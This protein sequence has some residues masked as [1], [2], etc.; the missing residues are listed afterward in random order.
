MKKGRFGFFAAVLMILFIVPAPLWAAPSLTSLEINETIVPGEEPTY[1]SVTG[2]YSDGSSR[3][4][5]D[6]TWSVSNRDIATITSG[7]RLTFTGKGGS[8]TVRAHKSGL[9]AVQTVIVTPW[10]EEIEIETALVVS[11]NPYRLMLLGKLSDGGERY[12][13]AADGVIWSTSNPFVAWVNTQ[14]IVTFTGE[15]GYV[16][17][18]AVLGNR[19]D[20]VSARVEDDDD[21]S[22]AYIKGIRITND[23]AYSAEPV[24]LVLAALMSDD[25]EEELDNG[26]ADW[27]SSNPEVVTVNTEGVLYFTGKAG[28]STIK[29]IYGGYSTEKVVTVGR[30]IVNIAIN[31]SLNYTNIWDGKTIQLSAT[32]KYNDDSEHVQSAGLTWSCDNK[33]VAAIS[34]DGRIAFTGTPGEV[35]VTV[36]GQTAANPAPVQDAITT[37]VPEI[38]K[39]LPQK[40]LI[41]DNPLTQ[42]GSM[43][44]KAS[45]LYSDGTLR[46]VTAAAVWKSLTPD[47]ASVFNGAMYASP[48]PGAIKISASWQGLT[49]TIVAYNHGSAGKPER[50]YQLRIKQHQVTYSPRAQQLQALAQMGDGT[51]KDVTSL[52]SWQSTQPG[53]ARIKNGVLTWTGRM[54]K[55]LIS[56]QGYGF[57]DELQLEALPAELAPRVERLVLEGALDKG[58]VQLKAMA[59]YN[60]GRTQDVT[61]LAVWNTSNRQ[62]AQVTQEGLVMFPAG[63]KPVEITAS[64]GGQEA[65]LSR[66][67]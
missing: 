10:P 56:I 49:D 62:R 36:S 11:E 64:Y 8:I 53:V 63:F 54:G 23:I 24:E 19:E 45:C 28:I 52:V 15:K 40:L 34:A 27:S 44:L 29:V 57:R 50:V 26:G 32:V 25:S 67:Q 61:N 20:S 58:A 1:L 37:V 16:R 4:E 65:L 38:Q 6:I 47:T 7:G 17:I 51:Y 43:A 59:I 55:T 42:A 22:D 33:K 3:A 31:E 21:D 39:A 41:A 12:L 60:D 5:T 18:K 35:T 46:D 13:T 48:V 66:A 30:F 9:N 2:I 14:G